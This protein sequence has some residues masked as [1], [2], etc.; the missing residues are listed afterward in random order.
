MIS[1][2]N[3]IIATSD[4]DQP[5]KGQNHQIIDP[6]SHKNRKIVLAQPEHIAQIGEGD[7]AFT[8]KA[9]GIHAKGILNLGKNEIEPFEVSPPS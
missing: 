4:D 9:D 5:S 3:N 1:K 7:W 6:L 2:D 8:P